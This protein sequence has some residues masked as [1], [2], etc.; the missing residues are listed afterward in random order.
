MVMDVA[1]VSPGTSPFG[2]RHSRSGTD[3]KGHELHGKARYVRECVQ[4]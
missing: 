4:W 2:D 1:K 3:H